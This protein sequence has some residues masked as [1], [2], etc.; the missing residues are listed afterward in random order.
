MS[1][2]WHATW[3]LVQYIPNLERMEA[4]NVGVV[5]H[6]GDSWENLFTAPPADHV[7]IFLSWIN[8]FRR[9]AAEGKWDDAVNYTQRRA[10]NYVV[11]LA[12][13]SSDELDID[14]LFDRLVR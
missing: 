11:R 9:K 2:G 1:D 10:V 3:Y 8:Y 6:Q 13:H 5:L 4:R 14:E 7:E 12:G